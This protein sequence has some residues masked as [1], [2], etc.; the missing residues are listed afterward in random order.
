MSRGLTCPGEVVFAGIV[1]RLT[2]PQVLCAPFAPTWLLRR[3]VAAAP[4]GSRRGAK[5]KARGG[6]GL[7]SLGTGA[8]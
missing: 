4:G 8:G 3:N 7:Q 2:A 1:T 5:G 6:W